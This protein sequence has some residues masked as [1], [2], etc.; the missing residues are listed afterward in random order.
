M[1]YPVLSE[2]S[3]STESNTASIR[4]D[5]S[6]KKGKHLRYYPF[7]LILIT[8]WILFI[9]A[10]IAF[11]EFTVRIT[12]DGYEGRSWITRSNG[13][14][15][16]F[17]TIFAQG[18]GPITALHLSRLAIS[19]LYSKE[20][21]PRT[22]MEVFWL[23][24]KTWGAPVGILSTAYAAR[25]FRIN[26]S[27]ILIGFSLISLIIL[28]TPIS[29]KGAYPVTVISVGVPTEIFYSTLSPSKMAGVNGDSQLAA[30]AG[31][32]A[33]NHSVIDLF[34]RTT[35]TRS[36]RFQGEQETPT[37][38]FFTGDVF[39]TDTT[40][41]GV[42]IQGD[43]CTVMDPTLNDIPALRAMCR[44]QFGEDVDVNGP[45]TIANFSIA[46]NMTYCLRSTSDETQFL[47]P[48]STSVFILF[49][50][51]NS[52]TRLGGELIHGI[53]SCNAM[54]M[55][56]N[57]SLL[58]R[59]L[60]FKNFQVNNAIYM[61]T[62]NDSRLLDPIIAAIDHIFSEEEAT[63][64]QEALK[65]N[66][67][68]YSQAQGPDGRLV[69]ISPNLDGFAEAMWR[70]ITHMASTI[71]LLSA[72]ANQTY[73]ATYYISISGRKRNWRFLIPAIVL[74]GIWFIGI[75]ALTLKMW[76]K[77]TGKALNG[78]SVVR[79]VAERTYLM[80]GVESGDLMDNSML[81]Q[82]FTL[83]HHKSG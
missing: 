13:L 77:T 16:F 53:I 9:L 14:Q 60:E 11:L 42:L 51:T 25:K 32:W 48:S 7:S 44:E 57:A 31:A 10:E 27:P 30:G 61:P 52:S 62:Q 43:G 29:L 5:Y 56:G 81:L 22:W 73:P 78:Y 64:E 37:E 71:A 24:E 34:N 65:Y 58:G 18:H 39:G 75:T 6:L 67:L 63:D 80:A 23:A 72:D 26:V 83:E 59:S 68:G 20:N 4:E 50:N 12:K 49:E 15:S 41:P 82:S 1:S 46:L 40:L 8:A 55:T 2:I 28:G 35:F 74:L 3:P 33:T 47:S 21:G 66:A 69:H 19:A 76:R 17:L 36:Q 38:L 54:T 70:G 45:Q 79:L